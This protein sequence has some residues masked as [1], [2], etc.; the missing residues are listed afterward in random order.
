MRYVIAALVLHTTFAVAQPAD[1]NL[2]LGRPYTLWPAPNYALCADAGD[3]LQLTDGD[4]VKGYFWTQKGTVG[5]QNSK[6][7]IITIDLGQDEPIGGA[8]FSTAAGRAGVG[9]PAALLIYVSDDGKSW[10]EA[11]DLVTLSASQSLPPA[12]GYG[13]H[14]YVTRALK[15]HGRHVAIVCQPDGPYFFCDEIEVYAGAPELAGKPRQAE[16]VTDLK[17]AFQTRMINLHVQS[18]VTAEIAN[19]RKALAAAGLPADRQQALADELKRAAEENL[20]APPVAANSKLILPYNAAHRRALRVQAALWRAAGRPPL[21]I[22][23]GRRWD[24]LLPASVAPMA[25][26][27]P[28]LDVALMQREVRGAAFCLTNAKDTDLVV[29]LQADGFADLPAGWLTVQEVAFTA[30]SGIGVAASALPEVPAERSGWTVSV[31]AGM[32]RQVWLTIDSARL[33]PGRTDGRLLVSAGTAPAVTVPFRL[34]VSTEV[35]PDQLSL[36]LG[37]WD[38]TDSFAYG[39]TAENRD[40]LVAFLKRYHVD[41]PWANGSVMP[42]GRHAPDGGL[43]VPPDTKLMD[44]WLARWQGARHYAVYNAFS[45]LKDTAADRRRVTEW[46]NFWVAHL[47]KKGLKPSQLTLLLADEP[48]SPEQDKV[49]IDYARIVHQAQ[50]EVVIFNDPTWTDP[51]KAT[52]ALFETS[53]VLC[54]NR[55]MWIE[56]RAVFEPFYLAQQAAGRKLVFYSC[57]GPVRNL[58]PYSYHRLQAWDCYRYQMGAMYFWAFGDNGGGTAWNEVGSRYSCYCP[59]FVAPDGVTTAKHMEAIR[60]GLYD[61]EYLT[62][63]RDRVAKAEQAGVANE[64]VAAAK[65][66]L[67]DGPRR[68][69]TAQGV[70]DLT[71]PA[72]KDREV[73]DQV[74]LEVLAALERLPR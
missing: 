45:A 40:K 47:Q 56:H 51:R 38:Y 71:W 64:A 10:Y 8:S 69:L 49:I 19:L 61:Y 60:E 73:A 36:S 9:W 52:P 14:R 6:P 53:T 16:A 68:V 74:R 33:K 41:T 2:A 46:I 70:D 27:T 35:M 18:R 50:P 66:L 4:Y 31:P 39:V 42:F 63:L 11:G 7:V 15:A 44:E 3:T 62:M 1:R 67:T 54:P 25:D 32:T 23:A 65:R 12:E 48:Y 72:A 28:Q 30:A 29:K 57:S 55:P 13:T 22:W 17:A 26:P 34:R 5:W 43:T 37:G 59:A 24:P 20:T 21:Q 58:D